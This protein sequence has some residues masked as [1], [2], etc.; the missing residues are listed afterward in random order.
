PPLR[1]VSTCRITRR[2]AGFGHAAWGRSAAPGV[3]RSAHAR[4]RVLRVDLDAGG[5]ARHRQ[6][7][8]IRPSEPPLYRDLSLHHRPVIE[9][10]GEP[11]GHR[12]LAERAH[13]DLRT[14]RALRYRIHRLVQ[15]T[16]A[17]IP[18]LPEPVQVTPG[19][20]L[21]GVPH[22]PR[23]RVLEAP[24]LE[25]LAVGAEEDLLTQ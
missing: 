23:V 2:L 4:K 8:R 20:V 9:L 6:R 7:N 19:D 15:H 24:A 5:R 16:R 12:D 14:V 13:H 25:V 21:E 17:V 3:V 10:D 1:P 22:I 18:A 11:G